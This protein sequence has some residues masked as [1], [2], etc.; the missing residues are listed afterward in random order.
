[1]QVGLTMLIGRHPF[2]ATP[3]RPIGLCTANRTQHD[4]FAEDLTILRVLEP[5]RDH[6]T[7]AHGKKSHRLVE[8]THQYC[9]KHLT[10]HLAQKEF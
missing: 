5:V 9:S 3:P 2:P 1:M 8:Q 10:Q 7:D 6:S 4:A